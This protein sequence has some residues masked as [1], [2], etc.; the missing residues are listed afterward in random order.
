METDLAL[1]MALVHYPVLNRNGEIIASAVTN[2]DLHDLARLAC[3]YDLRACYIV[4][5]LA[6]QRSLVQR[7]IGHWCG[8]AGREI[9]TNRAEAL[10]RLR[11]EGSID[12]VLSDIASEQGTVPVVWATSAR[13]GGSAIRPGA[14]RA[15][16]ERSRRPGLMM[17]G[18]GWGLGPAAMMYADAL[19][20]PI[21]GRNGYNHLSVRCAAAILLERFFMA[22]AEPD[23]D[24]QTVELENEEA[25]EDQHGHERD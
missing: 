7:L 2:L 22:G 11:L 17:L 10:E 21:L 19:M 9:R 16:L 25:A 6:D 24:L 8:G 20:E 1:Y 15:Q 5:P 14:A 3:T 18:T 4:T 13:G 12:D 23:R